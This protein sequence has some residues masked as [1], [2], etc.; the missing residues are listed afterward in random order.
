MVF[1][2]EC[3]LDLLV[4]PEGPRL[5]D[6]ISHGEVLAPLLTSSTVFRMAG[7]V[8]CKVHRFRVNW[9]SFAHTFIGRLVAISAKFSSHSIV[10]HW[11]N[12][13]SIL[14][15]KFHIFSMSETSCWFT[16]VCWVTGGFL[17]SIKDSS[18]PRGVLVCTVL[19]PLLPGTH[20]HLRQ[21]YNHYII[22]M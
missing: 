10:C 2:K 3:L 6:R 14:P 9:E 18:E 19:C 1:L 21:L 4:Q 16:Y 5:R 8:L 12:H 17:L 20:P 11:L 13:K 22:I 7:D 15:W